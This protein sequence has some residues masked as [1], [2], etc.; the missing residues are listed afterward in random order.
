MSMS[1]SDHRCLY[2]WWHYTRG[3]H[4][5]LDWN[6]HLQVD[7]KSKLT[8]FS[9]MHVIPKKSFL[10]FVIFNLNFNLFLLMSLFMHAILIMIII[11]IKNMNSLHLGDVLANLHSVWFHSA[12]AHL[13]HST[14]FYSNGCKWQCTCCFIYTAYVF[15][16]DCNLGFGKAEVVLCKYLWEPVRT[17]LWAPVKAAL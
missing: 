3:W 13:S 6:C 1:L 2:I 7:I 17:L 8:P 14:S 11:I 4:H 10:S 5:I 12:I 15:F 9:L 16:L